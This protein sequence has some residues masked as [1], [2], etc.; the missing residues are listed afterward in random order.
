M[1]ITTLFVNYLY[2]VDIFSANTLPYLHA[3]LQIR[4]FLGHNLEMIVWCLQEII[5]WCLQKIIV[6]KRITRESCDVCKIRPCR[7]RYQACRRLCLSSLRGCS[8]WTPAEQNFQNN[9]SLNRHY[10]TSSLYWRQNKNHLYVWH[11]PSFAASSSSGPLLPAN[12][13]ICRLLA[14]SPEIRLLSV[15]ANISLR[16]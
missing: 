12:H 8:H 3:G 5:L 10:K 9:F 13:L 16:A 1:Q 11:S 7:A 6:R 15:S 2:N 14:G 4:E